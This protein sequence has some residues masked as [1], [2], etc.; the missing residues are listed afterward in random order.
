MK[1][2]QHLYLTRISEDHNKMNTYFKTRELDGMENRRKD[3]QIKNAQKNVYR[4]TFFC[5]WF[6]TPMIATQSKFRGFAQLECL[7]NKTMGFGP[8]CQDAAFDSGMQEAVLFQ[9]I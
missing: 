2:V 9:T 4:C 8:A 5:A 3:K 6:G 1:F 7:N